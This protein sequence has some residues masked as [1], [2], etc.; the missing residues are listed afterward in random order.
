[1]QNVNFNGS[2]SPSQVTWRATCRPIATAQ[3]GIAGGTV[4]LKTGSSV[5]GNIASSGG[6]IS[7]TGGGVVVDAGAIICSNMLLDSQCVGGFT[8]TGTC[9]AAE[10]TCPD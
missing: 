4:T 1:L 9:P 6:G 10:E 2:T 8:G 3:H 5:T 7:N